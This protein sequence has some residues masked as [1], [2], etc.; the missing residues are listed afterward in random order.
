M[1]AQGFGPNHIGVDPMLTDPYSLLNPDMRPTAGS[2]VLG[3]W[4]DPGDA[5]FTA[6]S[7]AG[8]MA[9][10]DWTVGWTTT[11]QN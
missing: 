8:A 5:W 4:E 9:D 3:V 2:P 7:F 10:H 1:A 6:V 11:D